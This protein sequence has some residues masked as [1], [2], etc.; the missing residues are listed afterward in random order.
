MSTIRNSVRLIGN[1][2]QEP[3]IKV[4]DKAK[5][6]AKISLAT[7]ENYKNEKGE[8]VTETQWHQLV[9]WGSTAD[10]IEKYA[11]KGA[12]IAIEGKLCYRTYNDKEGNKRT[13][14]EIVVNEIVLLG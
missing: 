5:K 13:S 8:K 9:A 4:F 2:G 6:L 10:I 7:N 11:K 14:T 1:I 12:E 3:E